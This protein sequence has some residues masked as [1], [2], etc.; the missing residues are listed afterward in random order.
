MAQKILLI[1][2]EDALQKTMGDVLTQEGYEISA[3]LD[4]ERG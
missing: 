4:G 1:E 2:D 3:A